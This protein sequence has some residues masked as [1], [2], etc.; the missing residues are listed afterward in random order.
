MRMLSWMLVT[1]PIEESFPTMFED[2]TNNSDE[3]DVTD[4]NKNEYARLKCLKL[5]VT[6][7]LYELSA[8][9]ERAS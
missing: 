2:V 9:R 5:L 8:L 7:R 3:R 1:S 4:A 6:D